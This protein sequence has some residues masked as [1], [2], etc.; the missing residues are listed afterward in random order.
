MKTLKQIQ[1]LIFGMLLQIST[2]S[3]YACSQNNYS[4]KDTSAASKV[5]YAIEIND[6]VCGYT[7]S[8]ETP[9]RKYDQDLIEQ[10]INIF[11][12]L[13]LLGSEFNMEMSSQSIVDP[14]T[15]RG[16]DIITDIKQGSTEFNISIKVKDDKATINSTLNSTEKVIEITPETVIGS[17]EAFTRL[18]KDL[19]LEGK[20]EAEYNILE[21]MEGE[22][23]KSKFK[24]TGEETVSLAG[25][26]FN[27][28]IIEQT[29]TKTGL[30]TTYWLSPDYG[31]FVK[32]EVLNRKIY[33]SDQSVI[34]KIKVANMDA[35]IVTKT[36][37]AISDVQSLT[38]M[39]VD[40][41]IEPIGQNF[42][43]E[44]L[45]VPGQKFT[46][47]IKENLIEGMFEISH[48]KYDGKNAPPFPPNFKDAFLEKYLIGDGRVESDDPV[49]IKKAKEIT[50]GSK[51]SWEAATR[52]SKWVA[53]N[54]HYA[55]PG[56]GTA[57]KTYDIR[58]GE[59]GAHS[60][61]LASFC[62]AVGI[63]ARVVWGGMYVPNY[64]GGFGQHGWNEIYMGEA[65]WIPVDA[66]A[67]EIDFVD[68]GHIR[69]SEYQ[70]TSSSFNGK[71]FEII[72]YKLA[73]NEKETISSDYSEFYGKYTNLET[74][75]TFE[76]LDKEGNLSVDI[77]G[78]MVLPFNKPDEKGKWY[79]KLSPTLYLEFTRDEENKIKEMFLHEIAQMTKKSSPETIEANVPEN[80]RP[81]LG[82]YLFSAINQEF[83]VFYNDG[84]LIIHDPTKNEDIKLQSPNEE[85]GWLDEFDKNLIYFDKDAEGN[86]TLLKVDVANKF[87]REEFA[88]AVIERTIREEGIEAGLKK[89]NEI[90]SD[91]DSKLV[92]SESSFNL[93]GYKFLN[94]GKNEEALE[95]FKL[96]VK[97]YPESFNAH[98]SL[99]EAYMKCGNKEE[100]IKNYQKSLEL[101]P[102]NARAKMMLEKINNN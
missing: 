14:V 75:R 49:L 11:I 32:F 44:D 68:A 72:D 9:I 91:S 39:K 89:F 78:Q 102:E 76:V 38:Y 65:G 90:K 74:G 19:Y 27:T 71:N 97:E 36:N 50:E 29:N 61:L 18:K 22:I 45:N 2:I 23:Q 62:R 83:T 31:Y 20:T 48:P 13:S 53:E 81:Y 17:D 46:G 15:R 7:E 99:A 69:I 37:V 8:S 55:I 59:C 52:L 35:S 3:L 66:T 70:S 6:V 16:V 1:L 85:G 64:G 94:E 25:K 24:K 5:Y 33:L 34:D 60:F 56:G 98:G 79:C 40:A 47:T 67:L 4:P 28:I 21:V 92:I 26:S 77:P 10:D 96:N 101:N 12:M 63:P 51:D 88:S 82:K 93:L 43:V 73:N 54:I 84:V 41:V 30:K 87:T 57:R 100:A 42:T 86:V 95:I 80:M 58:A